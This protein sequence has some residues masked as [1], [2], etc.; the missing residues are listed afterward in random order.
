M[1]SVPFHA[2]LFTFS[3]HQIQCTHWHTDPCHSFKSCK[4]LQHQTDSLPKRLIPLHLMPHSLSQLRQKSHAL[5]CCIYSKIKRWMLDLYVI[6]RLSPRVIL[7]SLCFFIRS[8]FLLITRHS[9]LLKY[10]SGHSYQVAVPQATSTSK[11]CQGM[12]EVWL[13]FSPST[14]TGRSL[15][16]LTARIPTQGQPLPAQPPSLPCL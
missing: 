11:F 9:C 14:P 4:N 5:H 13:F 12:S 2:P 1:V 3:S 10:P 6:F 8:F 7:F 16:F 15:W